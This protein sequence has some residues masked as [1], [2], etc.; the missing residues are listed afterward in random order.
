VEILQPGQLAALGAQV[1]HQV[2]RAARLLALVVVVRG[3]MVEL[4]ALVALVVVALERL[5]TR[6]ALRVG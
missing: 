5:T 1:R 2:L 3:L 4:L 6:Q